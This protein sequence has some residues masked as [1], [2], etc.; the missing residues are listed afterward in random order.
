MKVAILLFAIALV[1][2]HKLD[3]KYAHEAHAKLNS[4]SLSS[5]MTDAK[6]K[7]DALANSDS[8]ALSTQNINFDCDWMVG[9]ID[10]CFGIEPE[11]TETKFIYLH[12]RYDYLYFAAY[13]FLAW[14]GPT[15]HWFDVCWNR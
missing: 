14:S 6:A 15:Y 4:E 3:A 12:T 7:L 8:S 11:M 10:M 9:N 13:Y 5:S 2:A 1:C